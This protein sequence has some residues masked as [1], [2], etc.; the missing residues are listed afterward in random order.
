MDPLE[1]MS[2]SDQ[3]LDDLPTNG[4]LN[5]SFIRMV[6]PQ[7]LPSNITSK[8][9]RQAADSLGLNISYPV[10]L[11]SEL[12]QFVRSEGNC[13]PRSNFPRELTQSVSKYIYHANDGNNIGNTDEIP[14][15]L[16]L[17]TPK[18]QAWLRDYE[19]IGHSP[20]ALYNKV[21][22]IFRAVKFCSMMKAMWLST[23]HRL[24]DA[25]S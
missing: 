21:D 13:L 7:K 12:E 20:S 24:Q 16:L 6:S 2:Q 4:N 25:V 17:S 9:T 19:K 18:I 14:W 5:D 15:K 22:Y 8:D 23:F 11:F 10:E 3:D 1:D